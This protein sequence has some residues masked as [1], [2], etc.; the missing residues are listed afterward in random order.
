[1]PRPVT[2]RLAEPVPSSTSRA[3]ASIDSAATPGPDGRDRR[4]AAPPRRPRTA[5]AT[6]AAGRPSWTVRR[7]IHA[8]SVVDA[9]EVQHHPVARPAAAGG[10]AAHAEARCWARTPRSS[11]TPAARTRRAAA[12]RRYRRRPRRSVRPSRTN[13]GTCGAQPPPAAGRPR[14]ASRSPVVLDSA[15][16]STSRSVGTS[17]GHG[18]G[19]HQRGQRA[20]ASAADSRLKRLTDIHAASI[21]IR[22]RAVAAQPLDQRLV[23]ARRARTTSSTASCRSGSLPRQ[24][25]AA[26]D[27]AK[28]HDQRARR[29]SGRRCRR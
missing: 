18:L 22:W 25:R 26:V 13:A 23:V 14:A 9:P 2:E 8:V 12:A 15:A 3:A 10:P 6:P 21:P 1:M 17:A 16:R 29:P 5:G 20:A 4:R 11:R 24:R 19:P 27:I 28:I 7:Q